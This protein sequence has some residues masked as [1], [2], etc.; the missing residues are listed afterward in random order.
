MEK[1]IWIDL[2]EV[3]SESIDKVLDYY[4]SIHYI[5]IVKHWWE[6]NI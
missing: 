6:I 2:D 5:K 3:L 4:N 1:I